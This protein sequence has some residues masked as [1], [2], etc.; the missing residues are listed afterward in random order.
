MFDIAQWTR[1]DGRLEHFEPY[2]YWPAFDNQSLK[3]NGYFTLE[4]LKAI[5]AYVEERK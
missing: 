3:L 5:V 1:Q 2:V 4:Q